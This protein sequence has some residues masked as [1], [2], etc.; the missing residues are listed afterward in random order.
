MGHHDVQQDQVDLRAV[1]LQDGQ[2]PYAVLRLQDV[3]LLPQH[4]RKH[5]AVDLRVV[6][7]EDLFSSQFVLNARSTHA[8]FL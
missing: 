6:G 2:G 1:F 7:D 5:G 4:I 3:V 8:P